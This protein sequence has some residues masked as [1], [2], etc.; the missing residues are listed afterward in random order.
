[1]NCRP[2]P[3]FWRPLELVL[4]FSTSLHLDRL[5]HLPVR[6]RWVSV[7]PRPP[8][9]TTRRNRRRG[10]KRSA[11]PKSRMNSGLGGVN[12]TR[13]R[14]PISLLESSTIRTWC[15][16]RLSSHCWQSSSSSPRRRSAPSSGK[17]P[18]RCRLGLRSAS[19]SLSSWAKSSRS[20]TRS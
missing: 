19:M 13:R 6:P 14:S 1:M 3:R 11:P 17:W 20:S 7:I 12:L 5:L 2:F 10:P 9:P 18:S 4:S 8:Q 15:S 16:R